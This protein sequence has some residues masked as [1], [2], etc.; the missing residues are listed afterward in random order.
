MKEF[1]VPITAGFWLWPKPWRHRKP[2]L[3]AV[4]IDGVAL[5]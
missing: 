1:S 4:R 2:D 5:L 3:Y